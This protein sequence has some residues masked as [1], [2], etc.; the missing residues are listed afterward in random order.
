MD[1]RAA[2]R[3]PPSAPLCRAVTLAGEDKGTMTIEQQLK[4][5]ALRLRA[6]APRP[7][8]TV[9]RVVRS[10]GS[11]PPSVAIPDELVRGGR[12]CGSRY[13]LLDELPKGAVV[14]ELGTWRGDFAREIASRTC[15][16]ELHLIDADFSRFDPAGLTGPGVHLH[17]G[18]TAT[19]IGAFPDQHFDWIYV[20]ADH[21]YEG[22]AADIRAAAPKVKKGGHLVFNDFAHIDPALGRYG[23]H[24]AV[25]EFV[26]A[27]RWQVAFFALERSALY[28]IALRRPA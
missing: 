3:P 8:R 26:V 25:C 16:R 4:R 9:Y 17:D 23:V 12:L 28:D 19:V 24:R 1:G 10:A 11:Y 21:S 2:P 22:V 7:L 5:F 20:D 15:P 13:A 27:A 6:G 14:A 18:L